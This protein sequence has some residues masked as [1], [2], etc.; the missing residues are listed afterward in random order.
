MH[1]NVFTFSFGCDKLCSPAIFQTY[2][3]CDKA[4]WIAAGDYWMYFH[5]IVPFFLTAIHQL[6]NATVS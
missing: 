3:S 4:L 1:H 6:I 2:F 5:I